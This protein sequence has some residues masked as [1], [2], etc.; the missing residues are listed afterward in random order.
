M[1]KYAGG[2]NAYAISDRSG[3]RYDYRDMRKEWNGLFVGK[4]EFEAKQP[5]LGPFRTV[6]DPQALKNARPP[7]NV[8]QERIINYGFNPVGQPFNF[9]LTPNPL[10]STGSVGSVTVVTT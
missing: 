1:S 7:Q 8:T 10:V 6:S 5:Q 3:F 2:K 4:D 9:N